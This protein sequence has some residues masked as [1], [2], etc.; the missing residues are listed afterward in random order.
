MFV[1][2]CSL[3]FPQPPELAEFASA[4]PDFKRLSE[5]YPAAERAA[6]I[7]ENA[8]RVHRIDA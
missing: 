2:E 1:P 6:M 5:V 8:V 3:A 4:L 7:H